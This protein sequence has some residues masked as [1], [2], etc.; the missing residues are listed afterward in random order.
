MHSV[1][2]WT[3]DCLCSYQGIQY[4]ATQRSLGW[5]EGLRAGFAALLEHV[6]I[7]HNAVVFAV[8]T[9]TSW[10]LNHLL[11][12]QTTCTDEQYKVWEY[13]VHVLAIMYVFRPVT[14]LGCGCAWPACCTQDWSVS[15]AD[16]C[17]RCFSVELMACWPLPNVLRST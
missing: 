5:A 6:T 16:G 4:N 11:V 1:C 7:K 14:F 17:T 13:R 8:V 3:S 9:I 12:L 15:G 2:C 10:N